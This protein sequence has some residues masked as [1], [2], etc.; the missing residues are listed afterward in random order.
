VQAY[1]RA[2]WFQVVEISQGT[3]AMVAITTLE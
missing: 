3:I 2:S 1:L